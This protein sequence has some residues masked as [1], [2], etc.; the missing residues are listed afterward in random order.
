[1]FLKIIGTA[2]AAL[3]VLMMLKEGAP[4]WALSMLIYV[5]GV[6]LVSGKLK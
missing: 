4:L 5:N 1:M 2:M 6:F 3:A